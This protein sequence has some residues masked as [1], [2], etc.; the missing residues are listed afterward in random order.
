MRVAPPATER[1]GPDARRRDRL[2][3][4]GRRR[5]RPG[6][7]GGALG[8]TAAALF[9]ASAPLAKLLLP[10]VHP[11]LLSAL[12]YLGSGLALSLYEGLGGRRR[13]REA[14][15]RRADLPLVAGIVGLGG[16]AGPILMLNGL[17]RM[18][19]LTAS[20]LLNLEAPLTILLAVLLF[21]EHLGRRPA[22]GA[23][24]IL[25]GAALLALR[26]G[27]LRAD[28]LGALAIGAACACWAV[29]NNLS[30]R[31]SLRDPIE[32]VRIK[33]LAAGACT[34]A[35]ALGAGTPLP[36]RSPIA[37]GLALG[38]LSYGLSLVLNMQALRILGAA[39]QAAYFATAPFVG[40]ILAM[41]LLGERPGRQ[42]LIAAGLMIAGATLLLREQ[43]GHRHVHDELEHDHLHG[44]DEHHRHE[45][46]HGPVDGAH[47]HPHRHEALVHDHVHVSDAHHRHSHR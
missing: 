22:A 10:V 26:S 17:A 39:R 35:L 30:Q 18:P 25:T 15:L 23:A 34:L 20:L 14:R 1:P 44:H 6:L 38:S 37:F 29:D 21:G 8:L 46:E 31:L 27:E 32:L 16:I 40:G 24:L 33:S 13:S 12:L 42:E 43:H 7:A 5:V 36:A 11:L 2:L 9:G 41:P 47:S 45:H 28:W 3:R 19:G 4:N